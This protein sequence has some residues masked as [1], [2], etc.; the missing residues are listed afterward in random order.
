MLKLYHDGGKSIQVTPRDVLA[1]VMPTEGILTHLRKKYELQEFTQPNIDALALRLEPLRNMCHELFHNTSGWDALYPNS[2]LKF[3][4][5]VMEAFDRYLF[6]FIIPLW[7]HP[8]ALSTGSNRA[9]YTWV[10]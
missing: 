9:R 4:L 3:I 10:H 6:S 1:V 2:D 7:P 8:D 5:K